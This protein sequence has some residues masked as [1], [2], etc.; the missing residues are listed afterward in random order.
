MKQAYIAAMDRL[1]LVCMWMAGLSLVVLTTIIPFNVFMRY[2]MNRGLSWPEP[3]A[4]I[5][6]IVFSFFAA[7]VCYRSGVHI[8]VMLLVNKTT[9][10]RRTLIAWIT[11]IAMAGF[12][13]FVLYYGVILINTTWHNYV[14]EFPSIRVGQTYLPLPIG[15][16]ITFLFIVERLWTGKFFPVSSAADTSAGTN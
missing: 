9:G 3:L 15:A 10:W 4:I 2:V 16:V 11:E 1:Y 7:A 14:A 13:L 5:F 8:S 6:M 12:N